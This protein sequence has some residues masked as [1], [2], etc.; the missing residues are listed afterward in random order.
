MTTN[1]KNTAAIAAV[2]ETGSRL[3]AVDARINAL[4]DISERTT[5]AIADVDARLTALEASAAS[6]KSEKLTPVQIA[7]RVVGGVLVL[8][9]AALG[10]GAVAVALTRDNKTKAPQGSLPL[11]GSP[12]APSPTPHHQ[13]LMN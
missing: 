1:E 8:A 5:A 6:Q 9:T 10:G 4:L 2:T 11:G 7:G 3:D 12:D 13:T